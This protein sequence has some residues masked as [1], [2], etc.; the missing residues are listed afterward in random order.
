MALSTKTLDTNTA[1]TLERLHRMSFWG[2]YENFKANIE[3]KGEDH[4]QLTPYEF[5]G[6]MVDAEFD[7]RKNRQITRSIKNAKFKQ[8]TSLEEIDFLQERELDKDLLMQIAAGSFIKNVKHLFVLGPTGAGKS[9]LAQAIGNELCKRNFKVKFED[10]EKF[11][12]HM[13]MSKASGTYLKELE[14]LEKK[15]V[16]IFDNFLYSTM[17]R[18][19]ADILYQVLDDRWDSKPIM[20]TSQ[21]PTS[22]WYERIIPAINGKDNDADIKKKEALLDRVIHNGVTINIKGESMRKRK[23]KYGS[24]A[25]TE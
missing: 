8:K 11:F 24:N 2:M 13:K 17:D 19:S 10:T 14:A 21:H 1:K 22:A 25:Q 7:D 6:Q 4:Q 20:I 18:E 5:F 16:I 15:D 23:A 12:I 9:F 3:G